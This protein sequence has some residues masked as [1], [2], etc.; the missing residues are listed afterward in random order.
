MKNKY[1]V[2]MLFAL[3]VLAL[4]A[5]SAFAFTTP[6]ATDVGYDFYDFARKL[7]TG[8]VGYTIGFGGVGLAGFFLF[9][10]QVFPAIGTAMGTIAVLKAD[11]I[12]QSLGSL[13]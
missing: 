2:V 5:V 10:Q 7:A 13:F 6:A 12:V 8:P 9:K 3:V 4:S 11:S 1:S